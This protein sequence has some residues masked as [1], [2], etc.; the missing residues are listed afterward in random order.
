MQFTYLQPLILFVVLFPVHEE[1]MSAE[2]SNGPGHNGSVVVAMPDTI[3]IR[4]LPDG[5]T[6]EEISTY[7]GM[8]GDMPI[9]VSFYNKIYNF[10][11]LVIRTKL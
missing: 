7:F 1:N 8:D 6:F 11:S 5:V 9:K 3:Y 10:N 4:G 2:M